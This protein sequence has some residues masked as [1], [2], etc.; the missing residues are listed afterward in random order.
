MCD[1]EPPA[2]ARFGGV[3]DQRARAEA[4]GARHRARLGLDQARRRN[5]ER[6]VRL[7]S[8]RKAR[9]T[10]ARSSELLLGTCMRSP[11][12]VGRQLLPTTHLIR[13][14]KGGLLAKIP[15]SGP[16]PPNVVPRRTYRRDETSETR[17]AGQVSNLRL[18]ACKTSA[19]PLSYPPDE[20]DASSLAAGVSP[21]GLGRSSGR[22]LNRGRG[23]NGSRCGPSIRRVPG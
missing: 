5:V 19:L 12:C 7:A 14:P 11:F 3:L 9:E 8:R 22:G 18:P 6:M 1:A 21:T 16:T 2:L 13:I 23:R 20:T 10:R 4:L 17:W 15:L